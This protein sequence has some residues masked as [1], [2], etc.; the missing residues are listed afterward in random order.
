M[1]KI[2][3][4]LVKNNVVITAIIVILIVIVAIALSLGEAT[5]LIVWGICKCF[6]FV[7][8]WKLAIGIWLIMTL[9]EACVKPT[10]ISD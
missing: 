1:S 3:L 7:F 9:I 2:K 5:A 4:P 8:T 6:G 10:S